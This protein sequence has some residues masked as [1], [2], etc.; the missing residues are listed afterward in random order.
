MKIY[1]LFL[2]AVILFPQR[3][4]AQPATLLLADHWKARKCADVL[5][6]GTEITSGNFSPDGW[7]DA[8]VP[9]TILTTLM[10]NGQV[11]DPFFGMNNNLIPDVFDAGRNYYTYWFYTE[12][13]LPEMSDG[14]Q[15]WLNFRGLNYFADVFLNGNRVNT[16][17]HAG[18]YLREKYLITP[19]LNKGKPN[20][21]AVWVA[22]PDPAGNAFTGQ[23]G[24][25]LI[26]RNIT[27]QCTAG[28]D[29]ICPI[30]DR[31]TGI[32]DQVSLEITGRVDMRNVY[33]EC[34][35]PGKRTPG[36]RQDPAFVKSSVEL[37]NASG[38]AIQGT[39][40]AMLGK[41]EMSQQVTLN[42][43][44]KKVI[45]FP[46]TGITDPRLWWPNG[47]G[48]QPLYNMRFAFILP[49]GA[50]SDSEQVSFG[51]RE[52]GH[53]FD[54]RIKA[55]VF[56][57]N[58]QKVFIKGG[59]WI[60]SDALLRLT[61]ERYDAEIRM[62]A[63]MN[64]NMIRV[65]GGGLTERPEFYDAC[66]KYGILVWQDLWVSGDCNGEWFDPS[67][68]ESQ[69]RRKAYPDDHALFLESLADQ[70]KMLRN[71]PGLFLWCGGNETPPPADIGMALEND[72]LPRL[73]PTRFYLDKST[74]AR[75]MTNPRGGTGDG[76]YG[77]QEPESWF[78][79]RSFPFNPETGSIGIPNIEGLKRIIPADELTPPQTS[80]GTKSWL[81]HKY[82]P[83]NDFPDRYGKVKDISDFCRKAQLVSY[84]Q[85]RALQEGFNYK[86]WDWYS[87]MLIWKNQ[88]PWTA[89]RGF[90]YD[91][92]L[93]YTGGYFGYK[94]GAEPVHLQ[95]N[96][97]D[98]MVCALN[99][100]AISH[101][102]LT[103][104]IQL[105]DIHGKAIMDQQVA[106]SLDANSVTLLQRIHLPANNRGVFFLR[107]TLVDQ[108]KTVD[109]NFYWLTNQPKS[110]EQLN[111]LAP[112]NVQ[113]SI[114]KTG[115]GLARISVG[116]PGKETAFFI[117]L[118]VVNSR[119]ELV[120]PVFLSDNYITLLPGET[121]M[122]DLDAGNAG[123]TPSETGKLVVEG[124]NVPVQETNF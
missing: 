60:A 109:E 114:Q 105:F 95:F 91:Y 119:N 57:V 111:E 23:G 37:V 52:T 117:R 5:L 31:N 98:S 65:W 21:L 93:D 61:R 8:V 64:M 58:G 110:Y 27:M 4:A 17:T 36:A 59:N 88:N 67:K 73:D 72:I 16:V 101:P 66:D 120:L 56:T 39:A 22:P 102:N 24:D 34:R 74:S 45:T 118:K 11:P 104:R 25:G 115:K 42:A 14:Q 48:G 19:Y 80:R 9:G 2:F 106:V 54:E 96:L 113:V 18:M 121:R 6:D 43:Y 13:E 107:L 86:M 12:F 1:P 40:K 50:V 116:N 10:H 62:H 89:L 87:G 71:H 69:A 38:R 35:V 70:V 20:K 55:Q 75:L 123:I 83:L 41:K 26:G 112:E 49:G 63:G 47:M 3:M 122:L 99:Q 32:W 100:T 124:W 28:W 84:E 7:M 44:E 46:E 85:Y 68:K 33:V 79:E 51:I 97:N 15:V 78:T 92:F 53:Y 76:P 82:L 94:H 29:W 77:I 30:R 90:F 108:D 81:Y 103:A